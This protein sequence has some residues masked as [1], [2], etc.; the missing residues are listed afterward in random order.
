MPVESD[1]V[2]IWGELTEPKEG[3]DVSSQLKLEGTRLHLRD[4]SSKPNG[5]HNS[6]LD[7]RKWSLSDLFTGR[8]KEGLGLF[9]VAVH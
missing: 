1:L 4:S 6:Q 3:K 5:T 9:I 8:V 7:P 2:D